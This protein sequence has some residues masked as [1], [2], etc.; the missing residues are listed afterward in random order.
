MV[1]DIPLASEESVLTMCIVLQR[2]DLCTDQILVAPMEMPGLM[3][4]FCFLILSSFS[5]A[6]ILV[7]VSMI[8]YLLLYLALTAY[9]LYSI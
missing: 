1:N 2:C 5:L 8:S 9:R 6:I 7:T 3:P 4:C